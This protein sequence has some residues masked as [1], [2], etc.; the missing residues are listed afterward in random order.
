MKLMHSSI[1]V[2]LLTGCANVNVQ[3]PVQQ[4]IEKSKSYSLT[5]E[6]AW[7][8]A[9]DW[10]ADHDVKIEKIEKSSGLLTAKYFIEANDE[11][12][13]CGDIKATG[14]IGRPVVDKYGS[15]N[16][17]VREINKNSTKVNVNFFGEFKL[18]ANDAWDGRPIAT[19]GRCISTGKLEK[20]ILAY[21]GS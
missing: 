7:I 13:D 1:L 8:R 14:T 9:V 6:K 10:F 20:N 21:I 18:K 16:V 11:Y 12:L 3:P 17:T 19:N 2:V 4:S 15:L 5:Y